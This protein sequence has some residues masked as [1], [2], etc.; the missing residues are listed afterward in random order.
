MKVISLF[1]RKSPASQERQ[2]SPS[3]LG[4][5]R[6]AS[7]LRREMV[8]MAL[9]DTVHRHGIPNDWL[10]TDTLMVRGAR[11]DYQ[12]YVRILVK[13]W[14]PRLITHASAFEASLVRRLTLLDGTSRSW[15]RDI[16]WQLGGGVRPGFPTT[17][18]PASTWQPAQDNEKQPS[19]ATV[20]EEK[21][22]R[23]QALS[24]LFSSRDGKFAR[25]ADGGEGDFQPTQPFLPT[26]ADH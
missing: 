4:A 16:S 6:S 22:S 17:M 8:N 12:C 20:A 25:P 15:L 3:S 23:R 7:H 14:E 18:P 9:R 13:H 21:P 1:R 2:E 24:S 11:G 19:Q 5:A 26:D 10:S